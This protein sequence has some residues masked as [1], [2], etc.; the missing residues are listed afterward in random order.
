MTL[1]RIATTLVRRARP[2]INRVNGYIQ[3]CGREYSRKHYDRPEHRA[4][5]S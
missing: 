1:F 3:E 4:N 2:I 5:R